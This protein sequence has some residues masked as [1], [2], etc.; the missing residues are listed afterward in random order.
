LLNRRSG[1]SARIE[2]DRS[3]G[4][5]TSGGVIRAEGRRYEDLANLIE[6]PGYALIDFRTTYQIDRD[7]QLLARVEN[8]LDKDYETA[9]LYSQPGRGVFVTLRYQAK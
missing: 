8:V 4:N 9:Y 6:I 7:W 2:L 3:V 1:Q 5:W